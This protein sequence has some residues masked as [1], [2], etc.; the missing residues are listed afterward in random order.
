[1]KY[2]AH[3]VIREDRA[4]GSILLR[5]RASLG[6][7][8]TRTTDWLDHWAT[9]TPTAVLVA[10]RSGDGWREVTYAE[11]QETAKALAGGLLGLGLGPDR[12][13]LI[14]SGNSVDHALLAL[15]AQYVGIPFVPLAEQ[16]A[17]IPE[18]R[19]QIDYVAT[20]V[21]PGSR[22]FGEDGFGPR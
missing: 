8:A 15:A 16:Y 18:A 4:D 20:L 10:E 21:K 3:D 22:F 11:A 19:S 12:P 13:I 17:L 5:A 1:M 2:R 6:P 7:I 14:V 9:A